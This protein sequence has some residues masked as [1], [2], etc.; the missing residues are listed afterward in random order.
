MKQS[1]AM[2]LL[3][4]SLST[5]I[6]FA[7]ALVTQ[8]LVFPLFGFHPD[9]RTNLSITAI[10]TGVSIARGYILRRAFEALHIRVPLSPFMLAVIAERR[11]Q[12]DVE[13][14]A[15]EHDDQHAIGDLARAGAAYA[16]SAPQWVDFPM[17]TRT[18]PP[19]PPPQWPWSS[20][21]WMPVGARRD[22][23][24]SAALVIAEGERFD[25]MRKGAR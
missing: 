8:L 6:G 16:L 20:D 21:W 19:A 1:R 5:A 22:L 7:I 2:S 17:S 25:R 14:W 9:I 3:E 23:V 15:H 18:H 13:G 4:Q 11:R 24:K 12:I 10:F